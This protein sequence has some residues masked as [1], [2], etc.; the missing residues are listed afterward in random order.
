[1]DWLDLLTVKGTLKSLLQY[2]SSEA[3]IL[4]YSAFLRVKISHPYTTTRKNI[5]LIDEPLSGN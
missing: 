3:S 5:A 4:W 2:H 1:M